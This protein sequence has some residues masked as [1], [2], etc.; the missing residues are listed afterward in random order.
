VLKLLT[1]LAVRRHGA[2]AVLR[3]LT[4]AERAPQFINAF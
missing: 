4:R 1:S 2:S 3:A